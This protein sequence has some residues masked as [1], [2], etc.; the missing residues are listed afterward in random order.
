VQADLLAARRARDDVAVTGL[1]TLLAAFSNAEASPAPAT[2]SLTPPPLGLVE[3]ARLELTDDDHRRIL[4]EQ[5][6]IRQT[7]IAEY[8]A[9]GQAAAA[10]TLRA[11]LAALER[12]R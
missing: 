3:H 5:I 8:D 7:A 11:E 10:D 2:S 4:G 6:E 12:Y 1:R 9:I